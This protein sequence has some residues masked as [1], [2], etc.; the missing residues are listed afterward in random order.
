MHGMFADS[1]S[2]AAANTSRL[3]P[4]YDALVG[5]GRWLPPAAVGGGAIG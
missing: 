1:P 4:A 2:L 3:H 5:K